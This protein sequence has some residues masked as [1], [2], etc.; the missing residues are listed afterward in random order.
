MCKISKSF[1]IKHEKLIS[2]FIII[3]FA[4]M[5]V[6]AQQN[7]SYQ[8]Y[9]KK[10]DTFTTFS[11]GYTGAEKDGPANQEFEQSFKRFNYNINSLYLVTDNI[12]IG[13]VIGYQWLSREL[14]VNDN[15]PENDNFI[16]SAFE[17]GISS[18][19]FLSL[20]KDSK[21]APSLYMGGGVSWLRTGAKRK[22]DTNDPDYITKFGYILYTGIYVPIGDKIGLNWKLERVAREQ[23]YLRGEVVNG[24][25][26][27]TDRETKWPSST[28]LSVG[29]SI[30]F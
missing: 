2:A 5:N 19:Y 20:K 30:R 16:S 15:P 27:I 11:M 23:E 22:S 18:A 28:N 7:G 14:L 17:Y 12:G 8:S 10:G 13:P 25:V 29:F 9:F 4:Q 21:E 26:V 24:E 6:L 1:T 3:L